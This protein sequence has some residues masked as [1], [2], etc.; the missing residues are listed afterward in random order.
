MI[1]QVSRPRDGIW[2]FFFFLLAHC[3]G[4]SERSKESPAEIAGGYL[5]IYVYAYILGM[6]RNAARL[7]ENINDFSRFFSRTNDTY[8]SGYWYVA[9]DT[10]QLDVSAKNVCGGTYLSCVWDCRSA[11]LMLLSDPRTDPSIGPESSRRRERWNFSSL[12]RN[13]VYLSMKISSQLSLFSILFKFNLFP[14]SCYKT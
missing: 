5:S 11:P 1:N 13:C 8:A 10:W 2:F 12:P 14:P 3:G 4:M 6:T 9:Q 7:I